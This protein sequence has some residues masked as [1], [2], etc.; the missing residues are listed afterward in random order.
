MD[1]LPTHHDRGMA[2]LWVRLV[3]RSGWGRSAEPTKKKARDRR[4]AG[5]AGDLAPAPL[6]LV[7]RFGGWTHALY[8][9][10]GAI[11]IFLF[12][13]ILYYSS[14]FTNPKGVPDSIEALK[15]WRKTGE[16][17]FH[18]YPVYKYFE[19]LVFGRYGGGWQ[20][21]EE[22]PLVV[23]A[24][25]GALFALWKTR[26]RFPLF[27]ALWG[28]GLCVA[29]SIIKYKTP[30]LALSWLLPFAVSGGYAV[31]RLYRARQRGWR[32]VAL[33]LLGVSLAAAAW[34]SYQ[35]NFVHYDD[36]Q[37]PYVYAHTKRDFHALIAQVDTIAARTGDKYNAGINVAVEN[38]EYW[39][40]PWYVRDY[41]H[42]GYPGKVGETT[43][44]VVIVKVSQVPEV[45]SLLGARYQRVGGVYQLRPGVDL[46]LFGRR[47]LL[48][49]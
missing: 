24:T 42:I 27:A 4:A 32:V 14:F 6:R 15:V 33:A 36:D 40:M 43:D 30:W 17:G 25:L 13:N 10:V 21:G 44:A 1:G 38:Q 8:L 9:L 41:K 12:V 31:D 48:G 47:D 26:R 29:Y 20:F 3:A 37:Y 23:L 5:A 7:E 22:A 39:P 11:S 16:S 28:F 18:G 46:A 34:Q 49:R 19:W 45:E 2:E 35:L